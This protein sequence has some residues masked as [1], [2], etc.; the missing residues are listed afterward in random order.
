MATTKS[1]HQEI[2]ELAG[3]FVTKQK[4]VWE[5]DDWEALVARVGK[6]GGELDYEGKR[7]LGNVLEACKYFYGAVPAPRKTAAKPKRTDKSPAKKKAGA[8][9]KSVTKKKNTTKKKRR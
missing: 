2:I 8:N 4:G 1:A 9:K 6:L 5:H 3:K 7:N